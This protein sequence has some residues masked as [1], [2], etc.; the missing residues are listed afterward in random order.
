VRTAPVVADGLSRGF[1]GTTVVDDLDLV[2]EPGQI[3]GFIGPSGS[4]KTTTVR[5]LTGVLA[6]TGGT[7]RVLGTDPRRLDTAQRQQIGYMP[8]LGVLYPH[9]SISDNLRFTASLYGVSRPKQ[10]IGQVLDLLDLGGKG[11]TR[12]EHASGGMQRRVALAAALLHDPSLLFLD[13][14][15]SGLDPVLRRTVW[16]HLQDLRDEGR[17]IFVTTQIVSEATMCDTVGLLADGHLLA[18]GPPDELRRQADGGDV[19]DLHTDSRIELEAIEALLAHPSVRRASRTGED[20]QTVRVTVIDADTASA[21]LTDELA[22][23]GVTV[24]LAE[25]YLTP[26]DDV[27]VALVERRDV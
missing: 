12:L 27:F 11:G 7:V 2:V 1:D 21:E 4:G 14:P 6:P 3:H 9:L 25:R 20:G 24:R 18:D 5:M 8:Q 16:Q 10:R 13:E 26:F 23:R 15:T 17:A 22:G 19:V